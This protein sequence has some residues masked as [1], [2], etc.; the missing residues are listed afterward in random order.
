V[1]ATRLVACGAAGLLLACT[2]PGAVPDAAPIATDVRFAPL[3]PDESD[4]ASADLAAAALTGD[5]EG[6]YAALMRIERFDESLDDEGE[7]PTGLAPI[8]QDVANAA[9]QPGREYLDASRSLLARDDVDPALRT[10]LERNDA[11]DPLAVADARVKE[12]R[13]TAFARA[14]N[15]VVQPIGRSAFTTVLV[16]VRLG[17]SLARYGVNLYRQ[18]PLPLQR[19]QALAQ[20]KAFLARYPEHPESASVAKRAA[21]AEQR[22]QRMLKQRALDA[23]REALDDGRA[24]EAVALAQRALRIAPD[25]RGAKRLQER[26]SAVVASQRS[27]AESSSRFELPPGDA[28]APEG[29]RELA[30]ALLDPKGNVRAVL[31]A[32]PDDSPLA[33][34]ARFARALAYTAA[35]HE[36][37]AEAQLA[38]VA[39][40]GGRMARHALATLAD[41]HQSPWRH[42]VA[43]RGR[44]RRQTARF[45]LAGSARLPVATPDGVALWLLDLPGMASNMLSLPFR[46]IQLPW[47]PP[48][49]TT[50]RTAVHAQRYLALHPHGAHAETVREWLEQY[51]N[52]RGNHVAA[53]RV[54]E[55]REPLPELAK[56]REKAAG[57]ALEVAK[58]EQRIDLRAAM[59]DG[60]TQRFSGTEA[61]G[62]AKKLLLEEIDEATPQRI[63]MSRRFLIENPDVAGVRGL[64]LDP[65]LIDG[66]ARNGELHP[67]GVALV[68]GRAIELAYV[69]ESGDEDDDPERRRVSVSDEQLAR[70]VARLEETSFRNSL[71][72]DDDPVVPNSRRDVAFERARLGLADQVDRR[73]EAR[74]VYTYKGMQERY[75]MVR[76]REA[77]LPFDLVVQGSLADLSL[78]AFPRWREPKKT[79][80]SKLYD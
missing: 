33:D 41:P 18:D 4:Q 75:G 16:P 36:D 62:E 70:V 14:F 68:G 35:G 71:L 78:G 8:A 60:I 10:R 20:W 6:A 50:R 44:D 24:D 32:L 63:T 38:L 40:G 7:E 30:L 43:A 31:A 73:P 48:A 19:R 3:V 22:W 57:Q 25:D 34:E 26:A 9:L 77:W 29:A 15:A 13:V 23:G 56:L 37:D 27:A 61:A 42:F 1:K 79:P 46:V 80:D 49:P 64:G 69:A 76:G 53:L 55:A 67:D 5:A 58:K 59:L 39:E 54:A 74:A 52:D 65:T 51:E 12:A 21:K 28:L 66:S 72:D 17:L 45:A 47:M 2:G 11:E